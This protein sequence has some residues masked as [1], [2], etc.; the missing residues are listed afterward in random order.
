M[1][2]QGFTDWVRAGKPYTLARP[3]KS[4][5]TNIRAHGITVWDYPDDSHLLAAVP[6]DHTPFSVTGFPGKNARWVARALDVMPRSNSFA[7]RKENADIARQLIRDRDVGL[8]GVAW[9]KY[10]N[11][12]DEDGVCRQERWMTLNEPNRRTT[13]TSGDR[14]HIH[15]SGRSDID[16]DTRADGYDP[17]VRMQEG[18]SDMTTLDDKVKC[19]DGGERTYA[20]LILDCWNG[21]YHGGGDKVSNVQGGYAETFPRSVVAGIDAI[22]EQIEDL[23]IGE[24]PPV[25]QDQ[26]TEAVKTA[27]LD[28]DVQAG[29]AKA[30]NDDAARRL[31]E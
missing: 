29:M 22:S 28:P 7:H 27:L 13:H 3:A 18:S 1:A 19:A 6:Q 30:V 24:L 17:I 9:I 11:W 16:N 23:V 15:I 20:Q 31:A 5:R 4:L 21:F 10:I 8:T 14:G 12:T 25:N 26:L 2:S